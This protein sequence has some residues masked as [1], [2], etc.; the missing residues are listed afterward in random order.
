MPYIWP[1]E[2]LVNKLLCGK[3]LLNAISQSRGLFRPSPLVISYY[4]SITKL[5]TF[6]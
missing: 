3:R 6:Y 5:L 4:H 2:N 1:S